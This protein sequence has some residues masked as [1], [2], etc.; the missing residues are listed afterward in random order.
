MPQPGG[1]PRELPREPGG[2]PPLGSEVLVDC[3]EY[4]VRRTAWC[5]V[6]MIASGD[7]SVYPIKVKLPHG[8]RGQFKLSEVQGQRPA[9]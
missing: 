2:F 9:S 7:A 3:T 6:V 4:G 8:G 5:E 1:N